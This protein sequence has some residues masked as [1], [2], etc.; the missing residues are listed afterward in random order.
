M[1]LGLGHIV[2]QTSRCSWFS[3]SLSLKYFFIYFYLSCC[4]TLFVDLVPILE[5]SR[6]SLLVPIFC[7]LFGIL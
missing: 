7:I 2:V 6:Y 1:I 3:T 5:Q 4:E